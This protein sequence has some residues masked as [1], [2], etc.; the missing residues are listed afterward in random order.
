MSVVG[1][2]AQEQQNILQLVSAILHLGNI[3]FAEDRSNFASVH[4]D[5]CKKINKD[6]NI[7]NLISKGL[8]LSFFEKNKQNKQKQIR[9]GFPGFLV[10]NRSSGVKIKADRSHI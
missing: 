10:G 1:L 7:A 4:D 8:T 2:S 6:Q 3:S 9:F 5:R